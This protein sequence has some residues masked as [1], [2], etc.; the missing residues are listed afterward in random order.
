VMGGGGDKFSIGRKEERGDRASEG[1]GTSRGPQKSN[2]K[3]DQ[4]KGATN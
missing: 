1:W 4:N 2:K 3:R